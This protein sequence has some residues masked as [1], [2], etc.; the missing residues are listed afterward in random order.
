MRAQTG[1]AGYAL[2][3]AVASI[4]V[5]AVIALMVIEANR[6]S[7]VTVAAEV[8][9]AR[10]EAAA[11]AGV[12]MALNDLLHPGPAG[13]PPIDGRVRQIRYGAA[14]LA[15]AIEDEQGKIPLNALDDDQ[16]RRLFGELGLS[17]DR[18]DMAADS[19]LDWID[20]DEDVR[21]NG[22]ELS[23][24]APS[25]IHP[26]NGPLRSVGEV[27]LVR[28]V[29]TDIA[30]RLAGIATVHFGTGQFRPE[31]A[32]LIAIRVIEG[33]TEG[34]VDLVNRQRELA[35]QQTAL[36]IGEELSLVGRP[37]TIRVDARLDGGAH[38]VLWQIA[39]LTGRA[40]QPYVLRERC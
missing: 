29:D 26:R 11:E 24:Y 16:V 17:G 14:N 12:A 3:A 20:E 28:G 2:V 5:F 6:G 34:A 7:V 40:V 22:A 27:A 18:L 36:A 25:G 4:L 15:I 13:L 37:V 33:D 8:D 19:F 32:S 35:G 38:V 23:F 30:R 39:I 10:A 9:R 31:H 21:P 1:E